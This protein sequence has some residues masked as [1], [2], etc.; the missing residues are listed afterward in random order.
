M[1]LRKS[2][3]LL[4]GQVKPVRRLGE[5]R[6]LTALGVLDTARPTG[7]GRPDAPTLRHWGARDIYSKNTEAQKGG[8][9][10]IVWGKAPQGRRHPG[11][12]VG[13]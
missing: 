5:A 3:R 7:T 4:C 9:W 11:R 12:H 2:G 1:P 10:P 8:D 13:F 6:D